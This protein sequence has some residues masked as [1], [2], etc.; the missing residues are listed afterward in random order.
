MRLLRSNWD[1][2]WPRSEPRLFWQ[3]PKSFSLGKSLG[4]VGG[5]FSVEVGGE[6][7]T[8]VPVKSG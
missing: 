1:D 4:G 6:K 5:A 2:P 8:L 7:R 3:R